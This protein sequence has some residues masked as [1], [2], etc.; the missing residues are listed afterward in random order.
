[1]GYHECDAV[2]PYILLRQRE[3]TLHVLHDQ[4]LRAICMYSVSHSRVQQLLPKFLY[5]YVLLAITL[6]H[7]QYCDQA[8]DHRHYVIDYFCL[9]PNPSNP[10][11]TVSHG[12]ICFT[13][14]EDVTSPK[15][16]TSLN[17]LLKVR[18]GLTER[19][20]F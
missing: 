20:K 16:R 3:P 10:I 9:I 2:V 7:I 4:V 19:Y 14:T 11:S 8:L 1:M 5:R 13:K 17:G 18:C 12:I 15:C 6:L